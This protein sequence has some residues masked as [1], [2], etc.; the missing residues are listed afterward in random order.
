MTALPTLTILAI[1][2]VGLVLAWA[3]GLFSPR[4]RQRYVS[5][6]LLMRRYVV[7]LP[8][9]KT[10]GPI[11]VVLAFH[12]GGSTLEQMEEQVPIHSAREAGRFAI[13]YPEGY[14]RTWNAG[15]CCGGAIRDKID[16]IKFVH[17]ILDD[18]DTV[19]SIDRRRIYATGFSNGAMFCYYLACNLSEEIAAIAPISGN[20]HVSDCRPTRP[21]P[22]FHIHG[23]DDKWAP[24][25]GGQ[26]VTPNFLPPVQQGIDFWRTFNGTEEERHETLFT[27]HGDCVV[28]D[29]APDGARIMLC[30]IEGLGHHW[31]GG[32]MTAQNR[33]HAEMF[34]SFGPPIDLHAV[35]DTILKFFDAFALPEL[36]Y[37]RISLDA[38]L[39]SRD[40]DAGTA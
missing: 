16:D 33:P 40:R 31:P 39:P 22:I 38:E 15:L 2:V 20:M 21:M 35:N 30:R 25:A 18:L 10:K 26:S 1:A 13:V 12:G 23:L 36:Q 6:G 19:V 3:I 34:G 5:V 9:D 11:A 24:F 37:R 17:A 7:W 27:G 29:G 8:A 32:R 28:Y 14:E 4:R